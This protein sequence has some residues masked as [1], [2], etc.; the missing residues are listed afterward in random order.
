MDIMHPFACVL[1]FPSTVYEVFSCYF[2][3]CKASKERATNGQRAVISNFH[4]SRHR[5]KRDK[6]DKRDEGESNSRTAGVKTIGM[7]LKCKR[8]RKTT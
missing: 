5:R 1:K 7:M 4:L 8:Q 3:C 2:N 6:Y